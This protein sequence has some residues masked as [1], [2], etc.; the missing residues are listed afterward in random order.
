[1]A[2]TGRLALLER[3]PK[4]II[5]LVRGHPV[6]AERFA[7]DVRGLIPQLPDATHCFNLLQDRYAFTVAFAAALAAGKLTLLPPNARTAVQARLAASF[8]E[9]AVLHDGAEVAPGLDALDLREALGP[10]EQELNPRPGSPVPLEADAAAVGAIAFTSGSTG[11]AQP[12]AKTVSMFRGATR[13]YRDTIIRDGASLVA[14]VPAQHMYGLELASLQPLW[15]PVRFTACKP[16][17]PEDIRKELERVPAPRTLIT[18]PLHLRALL[19]SGLAFPSLERVVCA[20]APLAPALA[21]RAEAQLAT[22]VLD[23]F[24]CSEAGCVA[25]R[26]L[27]REASWEPLPGFSLSLRE[28]GE[29]VVDSVH[30]D[31]AVVLAD[32]V[33]L[34]EDGRFELAGRLGDQINVAGKRGSL[35]EITALML[36]VPGVEDAV[37]FLPP[38]GAENQRPAALFTGAADR[39]DI[40]AHLRGALDDVFI[41]R[42]LLQVDQLPRTA[43]SKLPREAVLA[44][45]RQ[46]TGSP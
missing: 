5:A 35:G 30:A 11:E 2:G 36:E 3:K 38:T 44:L 8:G 14:T 29:C 31:E 26:R 21:R 28:S 13:A 4:D 10:P 16:L 20:T 24:G 39:R 42:P 33:R 17:F 19:D 34:L 41:P 6:T 25:T 45:Y 27:S 15:Y 7:A 32:Q 9:V 46:A 37:A 40:R 12:I 22:T 23:V 43:S 18:T 1:V